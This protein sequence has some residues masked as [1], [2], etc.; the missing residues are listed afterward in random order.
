MLIMNGMVTVEMGSSCFKEWKNG[1]V[2]VCS[3]NQLLSAPVNAKPASPVKNGYENVESEE[4]PVYF[5]ESWNK[6]S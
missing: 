1:N 5:E 4:C 3:Y 2:V 6:G